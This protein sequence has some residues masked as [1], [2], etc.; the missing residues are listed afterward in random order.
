MFIYQPNF[1]LELL[2]VLAVAGSIVKPQML[3]ALG[4][5]IFLVRPNERMELNVPFI[6]VIIVLLSFLIL[7]NIKRVVNR[8]I[9][10]KHKYLLIFLAL[11]FVQTVVIN[12]SDFMG[13]M[14][15]VIDGL[16]LYCATIIFMNDDRSLKMLCYAIIFSA[17]L[18]CFEPLYYHFAEPVGSPLWRI[19]HTFIG[20]F[21][22]VRLQGWGMWNNANELAF[23]AALGVGNLVYLAFKFKEKLYFFASALLI[24]FFMLVIFLTA[25]RAGFAS[26]LLIFFPM[27]FLLKRQSFKYV[28]ILL[29]A[30]AITGSY[31]I[32][33]E[34]TDTQA[35]SK[36][37]SELV[38]EGIAMVS[39]NPVTGMGFGKA[40]NYMDGRPLHNVYLQAFA[41]MGIPG[42]MLLL[43]YL[44]RIWRNLYKDFR[45]RNETYNAVAVGIFMSSIFYFFWANQ[46]LSILFFLIMAQMTSIMVNIERQMTDSREA[47]S[48]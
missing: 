8:E 19:F 34:R 40:R 9:I 1:I 6:P 48:V 16:V 27:I 5:A 41:E 37:R 26:L 30:C 32:T 47:V 20:Q 3:T 12:P 33:P 46:L 15:Y 17:F 35:S 29:L 23:I 14:R 31:L 44:F 36:E 7:L 28:G 18:I 2:L 11:I 13:N 43:L 24:P 38:T 21:T 39:G 25:S 22:N 10:A 45:D 4:I 42:G